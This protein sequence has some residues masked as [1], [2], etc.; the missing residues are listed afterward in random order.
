MSEELQKKWDDRYREADV[1]AAQPCSVV[2]A[3]AH[4][5]P[6][7]G[8]ALDVAS[9]LG[10]NARFLAERGLQTS[11]WDLSAIAV[12][13]LERYLESHALPIRAELRDV[14]AR[15]PEPGSF[16]VIV[17]AHFLERSLAPALEAAL[18]PGGLLFYQTWTQEAVDASGPGNP[19]FRLAPNELLRMFP[20]LRILSYREEGTLGDHKEG[21]RNQAWLV[22]A[23]LP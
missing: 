7:A 3:F 22:A 10:G 5:L 15:P 21:L 23:R 14:V 19:A 12:H 6:L 9:G 8:A 1:A 20:N 13:K 4:L 2:T 17:V 11:A 18:R 16:D